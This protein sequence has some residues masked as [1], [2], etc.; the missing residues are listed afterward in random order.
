M[1][2]D[3]FPANLCRIV[4]NDVIKRFDCTHTY[5]VHTL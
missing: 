3:P 2:I 5:K 1:E 4:K